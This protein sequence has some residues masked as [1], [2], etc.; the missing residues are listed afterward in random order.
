[1]ETGETL[2]ENGLCPI[3]DVAK[4]SA[5]LIVNTAS[6]KLRKKEIEAFANRLEEAVKQQ[7]GEK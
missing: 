7:E 5:R 3:E 1:M 4:I 2:R 6:L